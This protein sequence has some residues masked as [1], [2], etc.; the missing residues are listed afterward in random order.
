[1]SVSQKYI[2]LAVDGQ[3]DT[4]EALDKLAEEKE[5]ILRENGLLE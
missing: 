1:M 3:M 4:R 5:R 2:G